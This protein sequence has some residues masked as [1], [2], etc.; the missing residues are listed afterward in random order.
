ML[1]RHNHDPQPVTAPEVCGQ[2]VKLKIST[3][4]DRIS[5]KLFLNYETHR[6]SYD[7]IKI[8]LNLQLKPIVTDRANTVC[9]EMDMLDHCPIEANLPGE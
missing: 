4:C 2:F 1:N 6:C 3:S 9:T 7:G 8:R 5:G